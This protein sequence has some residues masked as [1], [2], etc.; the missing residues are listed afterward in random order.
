[1]ENGEKRNVK[2][3]NG[4]QRTENGE[5]EQRIETGA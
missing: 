2:Y 4:E 1:M 5:L 3:E